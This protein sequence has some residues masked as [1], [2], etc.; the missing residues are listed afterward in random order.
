MKGQM[1]STWYMSYEGLKKGMN[2]LAQ[3]N[4]VEQAILTA[5]MEVENNKSFVSVG[6]GGLPNRDGIVELDA[7]FMNGDTLDMG[8]VIEVQNIKNPILAAHDLAKYKR[9]CVLAGRGAEAY[10]QK[11]GF[12][13][14][15]LLTEES[16]KRYME[17]Q[18]QGKAM[19]E[20]TAYEG[21]DTVCV[22][23]AE[24]KT[25][26]CGVST[27][28]LYFKHPGRVGDS[29]VI[30]SGFYA[31]SE[32]GSAAATGVGE[33]IMKGCL[34][35]TIV[36]RMRCGMEVQSACETVLKDHLARMERGGTKAGDISVIAMD[37]NHHVGAATNLAEFPFVVGEEDG[38][39]RVYAALNQAGTIKIIEADKA[40]L[41]QYRGD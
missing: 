31:D 33:D 2:A 12:E 29:P 37:R 13:F 30:G 39:C 24:G 9:N 4:G 25:L 28:G 16:K 38:S 23:G 14:C 15:N 1:V 27:S 3:G 26:A 19:E 20:L 41:N 34:S 36:E 22:I 35:Y 10:A 32:A 7:A 8:A 17:E 5:V 40:W 6:Y 11:N 18:K 21:H